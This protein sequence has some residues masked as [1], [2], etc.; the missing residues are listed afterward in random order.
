LRALMLQETL[1]LLRLLLLLHL[2]RPER[3]GEL[4]VAAHLITVG[5]GVDGQADCPIRTGEA[6]VV[7]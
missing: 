4:G 1:P 2:L 7:L 6:C 5:V 3:G